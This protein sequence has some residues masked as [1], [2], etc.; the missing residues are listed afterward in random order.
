MNKYGDLA[1]K[2]QD[3]IYNQLSGHY[4]DF[5]TPSLTETRAILQVIGRHFLSQL[6]NLKTISD[7]EDMISKECSI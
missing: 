1:Q 2:V 4:G 6:K 7:V 3:K 5:S